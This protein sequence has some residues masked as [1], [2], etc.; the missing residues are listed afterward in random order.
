MAVYN[1]S[2]GSCTRQNGFLRTASWKPS[3]EGIQFKPRQIVCPRKTNTYGVPFKYRIVFRGE[4]TVADCQRHSRCLRSDCAHATAQQPKRLGCL[5]AMLLWSKE[6]WI[7][8]EL[9]S[10][11]FHQAYCQGST[12]TFHRK[13][14]VPRTPLAFIIDNFLFVVPWTTFQ[15]EPARFILFELQPHRKNSL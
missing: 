10:E 14:Y 9:Q 1:S 12:E 8:N 11:R 13:L 2:E 4:W 6:N 7:F 5:K 15:L 3:F